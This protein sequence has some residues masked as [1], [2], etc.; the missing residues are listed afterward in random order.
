MTFFQLKFPFYVLLDR[1]RLNDTKFNGEQFVSYVEAS[2]GG[3]AWTALHWN[4]NIA[5]IGQALHLE[6]GFD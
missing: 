5:N 4:N 2:F 3:S 1:E 6:E